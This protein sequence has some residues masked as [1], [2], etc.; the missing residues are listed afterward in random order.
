MAKAM[1]SVKTSKTVG[2]GRGGPKKATSSEKATGAGRAKGAKFAWAEQAAQ[3]S[4]TARWSVPWFV[5]MQEAATASSFVT[6][7]WK[8][9]RTAGKNSS[10]V[11]GLESVAKQL[12]ASVADEIIDLQEA[13]Q[14][15]HLAHLKLTRPMA[16][17]DPRPRAEHVLGEVTAALEFLFDDGVVDERDA[18]LTAVSSAHANDGESNA[19]VASALEDYGSLA[20]DHR[21]EL[22]GLGG[23]DVAILDEVA[24]LAKALRQPT[25]GGATERS[26]ETTAALEHRNRLGNLL[27]ERIQRVRSAAQ[28]VFRARPE[29]VREVTSTYLRR[30][31]AAARRAAAAKA[32]KTEKG[33][34]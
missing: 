4:T 23:F 31:R 11:P 16:G 22:D 9:T 1:K 26:P 29:I 19:A 28:Y 5:L 2:T 20:R 18:Q 15:A 7:H 6:R 33:V 3:A 30:Q 8:R 13:A 12:P 24:G 32:P 27:F 14:K 34:A 21:A 25:S 17:D 10:T